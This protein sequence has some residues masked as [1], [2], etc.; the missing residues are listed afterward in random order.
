MAAY[1]RPGVYR[2]DVFVKPPVRL[3]TGVP[4]FVGFAGAAGAEGPAVN[5]PVALQRKEEFAALFESLPGSFLGDA[6]VGFFDNGG[7]RCHVVRADPAGAPVAALTEAL[8]SL[9]ALTDV[10]LVAVPDAVGLADEDLTLLVQREVLAH[11]A[12]H[13]DRMAL[14]DGFR[15]ATPDAVV[16]QRSAI[17]LGGAEPVSGALYYPWVRIAAG[18]GGV[19]PVPPCGHVAGIVARTDARVGVFKAPANEEVLGILDLDATVDDAVQDV[20]NPEGINCLRAF[21]GRA[22]R[23][24]GARTLS[25]QPEW[26]YVNVRRLFLTLRR[27]IDFNMAW[28]TFEPNTPR[29]WVRIRRELTAY[30]TTLWRDGGLLGEVPEQAF[31]VK[32]DGE[33]N[34]PQLREQGSVVTEI[35]LAPGA[36]AEFVVVRII[37]RQAEETAG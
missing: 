35:G 5:V 21:P 14:L 6:V 4:G 30:L 8:A 37:H 20:L 1:P 17:T 24:W 31:Y 12:V 9:G 23:V 16:A 34:P 26:L 7:E 2:Q 10:D 18:G 33:T 19:R 15:G 22:I 28:A 27:W 29:L 3:P 25:R 13:G 32:C 36:P 11:C